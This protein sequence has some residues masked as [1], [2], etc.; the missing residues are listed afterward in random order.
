MTEAVTP[1]YPYPGKRTQTSTAQ[2]ALPET[3]QVRIFGVLDSVP[4]CVGISFA[5][6]I[7]CL[8]L[9]LLIIIIIRRRRRRRRI[10]TTTTIIIIIII[11]IIVIIR[12]R[13][14]RRIRIRIIRIIRII[15]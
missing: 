12:R 14:I 4:Q 6:N 9:L 1:P 15:I 2:G 11:I 13:R 7:P 5:V 10:I 3:K 8:W